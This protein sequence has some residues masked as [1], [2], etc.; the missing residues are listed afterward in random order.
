[1]LSFPSWS[2]YKIAARMKRI[3]DRSVDDYF[4]AHPVYVFCLYLP[5]C[6]SVCLSVCVLFSD[7]K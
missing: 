2:T 5:F 3:I 1:M 4:L 6:V 7:S